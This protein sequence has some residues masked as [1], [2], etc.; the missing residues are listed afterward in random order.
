M[1]LNCRGAALERPIATRRI[2]AV[3]LAESVMY[4]F[5]GRL[6]GPATFAR[7]ARRGGK[8]AAVGSNAD[9][10]VADVGSAPEQTGTPAA[11][12]AASAAPRERGPFIHEIPKSRWERGIPS[13]MG[14]H[15]MA[16]DVVAPIS[17][18]TGAFVDVA[19]HAF[20]YP[21]GEFDCTVLQYPSPAVA[22]EGLAKLVA[23]AS[24]KAI[25]EK[26]AFT[27]VLSGGS[28]V[29]SLAA[30]VGQDVEFEKWHVFWADERVVPHDHPDSNYKG[31]KDALLQGLPIPDSQIYAIAEGLNAKEA[32]VNYEGRLLGVDPSVLPRNQDGFPRF[33]MVLLG[34]GPDGH[35]ASLFPNR[36]Q[37]AAVEGWVVSIEDSPKPP[38]ERITLTMP[39][40]NS[41]ASVLIVAMGEGKA[42]TVQR[43]LEVQALPGALPAQ[44]VRPKD[45]TLTWILDYASAK[46]LKVVD[47]GERKAF[48]RNTV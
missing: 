15:L 5:V 20:K 48:P 2:A 42:E 7:D 16:S 10:A 27:V 40:I 24:S 39:V 13:V 35:V 45:G 43:V 18:S 12:R 36:S 33:D 26:G 17:T 29:K 41:A 38:P 9:R 11:E 31:A 6:S 14:A 4:S 8:P 21:D 44:L 32:A 46:D 3:D 25:S 34:I 23:A 1:V 22:A 37:T 47:W 19:Q 30:L 28:L